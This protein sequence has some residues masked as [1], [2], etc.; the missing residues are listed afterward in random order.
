MQPRI[1]NRCSFAEWVKLCDMMDSWDK[2]LENM[3]YSEWS[4]HR[5]LGEAAGLAHRYI[6]PARGSGKSLFIDSFDD[7]KMIL[8]KNK[9]EPEQEFVTIKDGDVEKWLQQEINSKVIEDICAIFREHERRVIT[10][11][12]PYWDY[13]PYICFDSWG[14]ATYRAEQRIDGHIIGGQMKR[15]KLWI[16]DWRSAPTGYFP[17]ESTNDA[18]ATIELLLDRNWTIELIDID[19]DAGVFAKNGG[20]YIKV[21]EWMEA[22]GINDI[23]I[24]IH[25]MNPVGVQNMRAIIQKN[26]WTEV[27]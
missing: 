18:I 10:S 4:I 21:L 26:G 15:I 11:H 1:W 2:S 12:N 17:C 27:F 13:K 14:E 3:S 16:D 24:R 25:S 7:P 8:R 20:D 22:E 5:K 6:I 23:P 19:H 9:K